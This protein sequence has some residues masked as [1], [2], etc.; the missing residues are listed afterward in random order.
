MDNFDLETLKNL[1]FDEQKK[2]LTKYFVPLS[3]GKHLFLKDN[4]YKLIPMKILK[5]VY[6]NRIDRRLSRYYFKEYIG[7]K[8]IN[9]FV[10]N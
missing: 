4:K 5:H 9:D 2:Y 10:L 3:N 1:T 6:F 8:D 7:V